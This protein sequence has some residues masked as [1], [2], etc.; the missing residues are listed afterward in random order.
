MK[1]VISTQVF[2]L[3]L[4]ISW[5][6]F[7]EGDI[8]TGRD[9]LE[10]GLVFHYALTI[11]EEKPIILSKHLKDCYTIDVFSCTLQNASSTYT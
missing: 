4:S 6:V 10:D 5:A 1:K 8:I 3:V 7:A 2:I 9:M 11:T